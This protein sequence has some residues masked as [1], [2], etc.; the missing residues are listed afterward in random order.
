MSRKFW[1]EFAIASDAKLADSCLRVF[2]PAQG[3]LIFVFHSLFESAEEISREQM[4]PQQAV[5][6]EMFRCLVADLR[7]HGYRFVSPENIVSGLD[8]GK[9]YAMLTFDDGY[10]NNL[11]AL[12]TLEE[13]QAPAVFFI[14]SNYVLTGKPFWWDFLYRESRRRGDAGTKL[15]AA[16]T[17]L[18]RLR[19]CDAEEQVI[20][21]FGG[22]AFQTVSDLDRPLTLAELVTLSRHPMA[23]IGNHTADHAILTNY[24]Y[25]EGREQI[26]E[27]Q[28]ALQEM[29]G[30]VPAIL[31][32]PNG[33]VSKQVLKAAQEAG[34][35][36]GVTVRAGINAIPSTLS[37]TRALLLKRYLLWGTRDLAAQCRVARSPVSLQTTWAAIRSRASFIA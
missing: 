8:P 24:P 6:V 7:D 3:L 17:A 34:L 15:E 31:A 9:R 25:A 18:K 21:E 2:P 22:A 35:R 36:L 29:T 30:R 26:L 12:P 20:A 14:S 33:N 37:E 13:F 23:H 16:R 4:D 10:A 19:T 27:T 5:T 28:A 11:R 32:Y 1:K